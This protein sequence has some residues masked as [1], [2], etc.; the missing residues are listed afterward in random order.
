MSENAALVLQV[1]SRQAY[2]NPPL[3]VLHFWIMRHWN[4]IAF[5][6]LPAFNTG[7]DL[8]QTNEACDSLRMIVLRRKLYVEKFSSFDFFFLFRNDCVIDE[9]IPWTS[10]ELSLVSEITKCTKFSRSYLPN[11]LWDV[12]IELRR[13]PVQ[14]LTHLQ[15]L[16]IFNYVHMF[17]WKHIT[18]IWYIGWFNIYQRV[19][20][21]EYAFFN[22]YCLCFNLEYIYIGFVLKN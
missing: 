2:E 1:T 5:A 20:L 12:A 18:R 15:I 19:V 17:A 7:F 14:T 11:D 16:F 9:R 4:C 13:F 10:H 3:Y 22:W 8:L 21:N 6:D